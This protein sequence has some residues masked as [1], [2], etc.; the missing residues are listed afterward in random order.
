MY[1]SPFDPGVPL[2]KPP[3]RPA[4]IRTSHPGGD[5]HLRTQRSPASA[6]PTIAFAWATS[7]SITRSATGTPRTPFRVRSTIC[8]TGSDRRS[9]RH[10]RRRG[11]RAPPARVRR[12]VPPCGHKSDR[13]AEVVGLHREVRCES[14]CG[15]SLQEIGPADPAGTSLSIQGSDTRSR[16]TTSHTHRTPNPTEPPPHTHR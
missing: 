1:G 4:C 2:I 9:V 5:R 10:A 14:C 13:S 16:S 3:A 15:T 8:R 11:D 7:N 12:S 6:P